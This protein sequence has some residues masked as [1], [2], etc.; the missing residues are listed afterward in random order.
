[1]KGTT[2]RARLQSGWFNERVFDRSETVV[3]PYYA[4]ATDQVYET[5]RNNHVLSIDHDFGPFSRVNTV[6]SYARYRYIRNTIRKDMVSLNEQLTADPADDDTT[7]FSAVFGRATWTK[8]NKDKRWELL[9]GIDLNYETGSGKRTGDVDRTMT[10]LGV[11]SSLLYTPMK[12]LMFRPS[13]RFIYNSR[14]EAP[15]VPGM[16]IKW[17]ASSTLSFRG[18]WSRGYRAPSLKELYLMFVDN[19]L[20]NIRGNDQLSAERSHHTQIA[21]EWRKAF[22]KHVFVVEPSVFYNLITDKIALLQFDQSS[23]LYTYRNIDRFSA[24]GTEFRLRY[25]T[26]CNAFSYGISVT[27]TESTINGIDLQQSAAWFV[28]HSLSVE[29]KVV[30]TGTSFSLFIKHNGTQPVFLTNE[31]GGVRRFD[32]PSFTLMDL[33]VLQTLFSEKLLL[34]GGVKNLLGVTNIVNSGAAGVHSNLSAGSTP[35]AT[36]TSFFLKLTW[37]VR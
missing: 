37:T 35:V 6:A 9:S 13:V 24:R 14:F 7:R 26:D 34:S 32:N 3:T 15:P 25:A 36:G 2:T 10:D 27:G 16:H 21:L 5:G 8:S 18:S 23:T 28:E 1:L 19:G 4:Y 29:Q 22:G 33:S 30:R 17:D 12:G 11:Y 20:H 31:A